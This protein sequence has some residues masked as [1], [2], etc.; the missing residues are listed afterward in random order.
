ME[1]IQHYLIVRPASTA[2]DAQITEY[3]QASVNG[4]DD[5]NKY[6][7]QIIDTRKNEISLSFDQSLQDIF[8]IPAFINISKGIKTEVKQFTTDLITPLKSRVT[9]LE[10]KA[11]NDRA[12]WIQRVESALNAAG[13]AHNLLVVENDALKV[14]VN[15]LITNYNTLLSQV[16]SLEN[17]QV[18]GLTD[19]AAIES[20]GIIEQAPII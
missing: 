18:N 11:H 15:E 8:N 2:T 7:Q 1:T 20:T 6:F 13:N 19:L 12:S 9:V 4:H 17:E 16:S 5:G 10:Q 14:K 3:S